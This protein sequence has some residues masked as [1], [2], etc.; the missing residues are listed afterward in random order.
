MPARWEWNVPHKK[1]KNTLLPT[2]NSLNGGLKDMQYHPEINHTPIQP[3]GLF[4]Q[5]MSCT[6]V[7]K[8]TVNLTT[9]DNCII[10][11]ITIKDR[12]TKCYKRLPVKKFKDVI[13]RLIPFCKSLLLKTWKEWL[14]LLAGKKGELSFTLIQTG[15]DKFIAL[16]QKKERK[17]KHK[18]KTNSIN[19]LVAR[20]VKGRNRWALESLAFPLKT[21]RQ[22]SKLLIFNTP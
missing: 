10:I 20:T 13:N 12:P 2:D 15:H 5:C 6:G 3:T 9:L 4:I 14:S 18:K 7:I 17:K 16:N 21:G 1:A 11:A 19:I 22:F 8:K